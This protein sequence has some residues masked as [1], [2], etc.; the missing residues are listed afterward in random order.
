MIIPV[1]D[2]TLEPGPEPL[3]TS[4]C[5]GHR[6]R[7]L[8]CLGSRWLYSCFQRC[9]DGSRSTT[10]RP[11]CSL[12]KPSQHNKAHIPVHA[13]QLVQHPRL[14][15]NH[16]PSCTVWICR[17]ASAS[18]PTEGRVTDPPR[19]LLASPPNPP[20]PQLSLGPPDQ[21]PQWIINR[22]QLLFSPCVTLVLLSASFSFFFNLQLRASILV[23]LLF[24]LV[25]HIRSAFELPRICSQ[26][27]LHQSR[28]LVGI[29]FQV[30]I[31]TL[32]SS[33]LPSPN[34]PLHVAAD[35]VSPT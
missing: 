2:Q 19:G 7:L 14:R 31:L 9:D 21:P 20:S 32:V 34:L 16:D 10:P 11:T 1:C 29:C 4:L 22:V 3:S 13:L 30:E 26:N 15:C 27:T 24:S 5:F 6:S 28:F 8:P 18:K 25:L 12:P 35:R 33:A 17:T 23:V